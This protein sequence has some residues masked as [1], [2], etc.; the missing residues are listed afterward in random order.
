MV[1]KGHD[2]GQVIPVQLRFQAEE[3]G[4]GQAVQQG[5]GHA[6]SPVLALARRLAPARWSPSALMT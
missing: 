4:V 3:A 6:A 5:G 2:H 1:G